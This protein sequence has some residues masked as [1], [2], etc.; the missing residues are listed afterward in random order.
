MSAL[1]WK[2]AVPAGQYAEPSEPSMVRQGN[3]APRR[4]SWAARSRATGRVECRQRS[5]SAAA[6][7]TVQISRGSTKTS[8]SQKACPS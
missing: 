3:A 6:S 8:V 4:P 1:T 5:A 7:G 2:A